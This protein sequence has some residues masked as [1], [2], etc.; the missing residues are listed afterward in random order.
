MIAAEQ[1]R[2]DVAEHRLD[3]GFDLRARRRRL[4]GDGEVAGV[5]QLREIGATLGEVV[6]RWGSQRRN[7]ELASYGMPSSCGSGRT[8]NST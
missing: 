2:R 1:D 8:V 4:F 3:A 6:A 7:D 5:R